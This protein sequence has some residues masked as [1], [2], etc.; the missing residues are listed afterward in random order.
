MNESLIAW[1]DYTPLSGVSKLQSDPRLQSLVKSCFCYIHLHH[2]VVHATLR[3][4]LTRTISIMISADHSFQCWWWLSSI[5]EP[6]PE[7]PV[8]VTSSQIS[9]QPPAGPRPPQPPQPPHC[10]P[11]GRAGL[12]RTGQTASP[13]T[14]RDNSENQWV[15]SLI[16][17]T[18]C[19]NMVTWPW[20]KAAS[21]TYECHLV[22]L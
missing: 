4:D 13:S 16:P 19:I 10:H 17:E 1:L 2:R 22:T 5:E 3:I 7:P 12:C 6:S 11:A 9:S 15:K 8:T 20:L 18:D 14:P 21:E